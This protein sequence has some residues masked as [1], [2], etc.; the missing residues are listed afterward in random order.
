MVGP[1]Y[2]PPTPNLPAS[3]RSLH[4][5]ESE[6]SAETESLD[7]ESVVQMIQLGSSVSGHEHAYALTAAECPWWDFFLDEDL[8][9]LIALQRSRSPR[10]HE[11]RASI[12]QAWHQRWVLKRGFFPHFENQAG[13]STG[14][15]GSGG[16]RM[17][18]NILLAEMGWEI[19]I[20]GGR[21]RS[22]EVLHRNLEAQVET[23]RNGMVF[24]AGEIGLF[25][26][27]FRV[28]EARIELQQQNIEFY[29]EV[30]HLTEQKLAL[31]GIAEIDLDESRARL[32]RER[33]LLPDLERRR[34]QARIEL[35]RVVGVYAEELDPILD[36]LRPIPTP[37]SE[38]VIPNPCD[39][40][41]LRPD[42]RRLERK[43]G[44][45]VARVAVQYAEELYPKFSFNYV[46]NGG[47]LLIPVINR[48]GI[49]FL[50]KNAKRIIATEIERTKIR[51]EQAILQRELHNYE[52]GL[53]NAASEVESAVIDLNIAHKKQQALERA[54]AS[55]QAAF[56]RV[57]DAY[58]SGLVDVRDIIRIR[59]DLF[60]TQTELIFAQNLR[61]KGA[62]RL[63][64]AVGGIDVPPVP[65]T[66]IE[67]PQDVADISDNNRF[68]SRLFSLNRDTD[69]TLR[70]SRVK[71]RIGHEPWYHLTQD[72]VLKNGIP[73]ENPFL[74][75][76]WNFGP[77]TYHLSDESPAP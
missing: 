8:R 36:R 29:E 49:G 65:A 5:F 34:D 40:L 58:R 15:D 46:F 24:L 48:H 25:Y 62:V 41:P 47:D 63:Y 17:H 37:G 61:A 13:Y 20:F 69:D 22:V 19:D 55:N 43:I 51:E 50:A 73:N 14:L 23:F 77:T 75:R 68:L 52:F 30:V 71:A 26:T 10:L 64:K 42:I 66:M 1:N 67:S 7:T 28:N 33:A 21:Q 38:I 76:M 54:L 18:D 27:D 44:A 53:V 9:E 2:R 74:N 35:A 16:G 45:Q 59:A 70:T 12:D 57:Y 31:G 11:L 72:G 56:E 39:V 4:P 3:W 6:L 32:E 60:F